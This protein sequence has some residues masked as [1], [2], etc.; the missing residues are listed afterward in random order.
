[1]ELTKGFYECTMRSTAAGKYGTFEAGKTYIMSAEAAKY[2]HEADALVDDPKRTER[3]PVEAPIDPKLAELENKY[4]EATA[5]RS[6]LIAQ[7]EQHKVNVTVTAQSA[8][9]TEAR[10]KTAENALVDCRKELEKVQAENAKLKM[11]TK[12]VLQE[13]IQGPDGPVG[14][15]TV[16]PIKGK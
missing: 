4:K 3:R 7:L 11:A 13:P 9:D 1:M 5:E 10:A 16:T 15:K 14:T 2:F 6:A 12:T 8:A